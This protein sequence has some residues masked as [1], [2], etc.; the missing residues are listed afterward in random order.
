MSRHSYHTQAGCQTL[1][2]N[3]LLRGSASRLT[4]VTH[5]SDTRGRASTALRS[6]AEPGNEISC[7]VAI[8]LATA[9]LLAHCAVA[10]AQIADVRYGEVVPRDVREM[11][12]RGL[13]YL[14]NSQSERGDWTGGQTGPGITGL[15]VMVF[16]A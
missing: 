11:Y 9:L 5:H 16:L 7:T 1:P 10:S 12:D 14:A 4:S 3:P 2:G 6:R 15:A 8:G 13:Q